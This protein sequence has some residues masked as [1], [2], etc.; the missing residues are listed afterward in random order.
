MIAPARLNRAWPII[1]LGALLVPYLL[2]PFVGDFADAFSVS[3]IWDSLWPILFGAVLTVLLSRSGDRLPRIPPG[4]AIGVY[5]ALFR[6][7][8]APAPMIERID[9]ALRRWPLGGL[10]LLAIALVLAAAT[11]Y[12]G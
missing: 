1:A 10:A 2:F 9:S 11:A 6:R 4:D 5:E 3:K 8:L 12:A 7:S